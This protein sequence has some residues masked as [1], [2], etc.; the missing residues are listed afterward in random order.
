MSGALKEHEAIFGPR[1]L[2]AHFGEIDTAAPFDAKRSYTVLRC[3]GMNPTAIRQKDDSVSVSLDM[4]RE[5]TALQKKR[6][7]AAHIWADAKDPD[8]KK[9][10]A[11]VRRICREFTYLG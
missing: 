8:R 4:W 6:I 2:P 5:A 9:Q 11:Y 10:G 7:S 3:S 1:P